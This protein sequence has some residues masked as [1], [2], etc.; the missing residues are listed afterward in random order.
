[1][2]INYVC[3]VIVIGLAAIDEPARLRASRLI[4]FSGL[5]LY[6]PAMLLT[7]SAGESM[8]FGWFAIAASI[9]FV[10]VPRCEAGAVASFKLGLLVRTASA[11]IVL[12]LVALARGVLPY[13]QHLA[14]DP[15]TPQLRD[16]WK[17]V[18]EL[19]STDSLVFTDQ[20]GR[21]P[22]L[23]GGWNTYALHGQRQVY[24]ANWYQSMLLRNNPEQREMRLNTN[25]DVLSGRLAPADATVTRKYNGFYAVVSTNRQ[26]DAHWHR[27][28]ANDAY[29][30]YKWD[31]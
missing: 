11:V 20:V 2:R 23:L 31:K 17:E 16:I 13:T 19:S 18:R 15:L 8:G 12:A 1:M 21:Q 6:L 29:S 5:L 26:M 7:D 27:I 22:T 28:Y 30:L 25:D 10:S 14:T 4:A 3:A 9:I 24:H